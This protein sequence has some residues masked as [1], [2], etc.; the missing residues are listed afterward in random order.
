MCTVSPSYKPYERNLYYAP[1]ERLCERNSIPFTNL[2]IDAEIPFSK[3]CFQDQSHMN[4][5][6]AELYSR[7]V[8]EF[9]RHK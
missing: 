2:E 4:D 9:I 1:I 5:T 8:C 3:S 6:G 7:K